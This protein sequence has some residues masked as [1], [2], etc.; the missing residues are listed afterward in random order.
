AGLAAEALGERRIAAPLRRQHLDGHHAIELA[1]PRLVDGAHAALAE[2]FQD[3][4]IWKVRSQLG[5]GGNGGQVG[6]RRRGGHLVVRGSFFRT[7]ALDG[8]LHQTLRAKPF[9][10]IRGK[11]RATDGTG[12]QDARWSY[13]G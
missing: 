12:A 9:A 4:K 2:Q 8:T 13:R 3:F 7:G 5:G 11:F 10:R 6:E 1:L